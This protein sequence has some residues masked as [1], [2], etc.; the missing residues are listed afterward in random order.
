VQEAGVVVG[1]G[2]GTPVGVA[3]LLAWIA[4]LRTVASSAPLHLVV[5]CAPTDRFRRNE[6]ATEIAR[7]FEP[8]SLLFVPFDR[9]VDAAAWHGALVGRGPFTASLAPLGD[10][11]APRPVPRRVAERRQAR[12][13]TIAMGARVRTA[14][15]E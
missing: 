3:R 14:G 15:Y 10:L 7:T 1:V 4:E 13:R 12:R 5:N 2:S 8:T 6:I 9:K 11:V